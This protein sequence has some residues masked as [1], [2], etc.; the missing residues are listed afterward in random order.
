MQNIKHIQ[1]SGFATTPY[2]KFHEFCSTRLWF[3]QNQAYIHVSMH[4]SCWQTEQVHHFTQAGTRTQTSVHKARLWEVF[5]QQ[6]SPGWW[7]LVKLPENIMKT[8]KQEE[9]GEPRNTAR[10]PTAQWPQLTR[11]R[12]GRRWETWA[13][14][15]YK[16]CLSRCRHPII[17]VI[18]LFS[19]ARLL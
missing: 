2:H 7:W 16:D 1:R 15:Q 19:M 8:H 3:Q 11:K 6:Q 14:L 13:T 18:R 5:G 12:E 4:S 10:R 17:K 9:I